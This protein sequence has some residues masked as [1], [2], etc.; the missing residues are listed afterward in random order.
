MFRRSITLC[1][2]GLASLAALVSACGGSQPPTTGPTPATITGTDLQKHIG[3]ERQQTAADDGK[4]RF[5]LAY[6]LWLETAPTPQGTRPDPW[7]RVTLSDSPGRAVNP[8][9]YYVFRFDALAN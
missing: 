7:L 4:P 1:W 9:E 6:Q 2:L 5:I 8:H 3:I